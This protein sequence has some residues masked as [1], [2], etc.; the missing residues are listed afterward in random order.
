MASRAQFDKIQRLIQVGIDEGAEVVA[1]GPGRPDGLEVG[2]YV[3]PT[4]L[5]GVRNA[6]GQPAGALVNPPLQGLAAATY[7]QLDKLLN[8]DTPT[9]T[10]PGAGG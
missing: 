10:T 5:A 4:V 1:G 2:Y 7:Q 8:D 9:P 3:R 6:I